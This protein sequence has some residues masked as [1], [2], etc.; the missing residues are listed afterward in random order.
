MTYTYAKYDKEG[1]FVGVTS[2]SRPIT[3][4]LWSLIQTELPQSKLALS[5]LVNGEL[6][7]GEEI[8]ETEPPLDDQS[9]ILL[10]REKRN[11]ML[12]ES[13]W[14]QVADAPV[15]QAAWAV[16]RQQL[17]DLPDQ[18][19]FPQDVAWPTKP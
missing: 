15:D 13:D 3:Q 1:K 2:S 19:G 11:T 12:A 6:V 18:P 17:R 4:S 14:T 9:T 5:M 8:T 16:Y 10:L 7:F